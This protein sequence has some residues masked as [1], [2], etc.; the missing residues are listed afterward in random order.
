MIGIALLILVVMNVGALGSRRFLEDHVLS[1]LIILGFKVEG[2]A[3]W[4]L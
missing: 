4:G 3:S 2:V 1:K